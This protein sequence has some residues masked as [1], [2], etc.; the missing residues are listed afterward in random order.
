MINGQKQKIGYVVSL[1]PCWSETFILNEI[2]ELGKAGYDITIF[3]IR[4]DFE[5]YT[6]EKA[7]AYLSRTR[8]IAVGN[9][10]LSCLKWCLRKPHV[11][12]PWTVKIKW[13]SLKNP[14][15]FHK[16]VWCILVACYFADLAEEER[17]TH[18]HAHFA[19]YPALVALLMGK[20]TGINYTL[21]THAHDIFLDKTLLKEKIQN[22]TAVATISEYNRR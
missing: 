11:L 7:K 17:I 22:A 14:R 9:M 19:T 6:Q 3:S 1:F 5:T 8:Y 21:T 10:L 2:I 4:K 12:L 18:L 13:H 16:N 15:I 20:L